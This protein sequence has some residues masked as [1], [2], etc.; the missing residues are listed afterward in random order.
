M[1]RKKSLK[2]VTAGGDLLE[3][4]KTLALSLAEELDGENRGNAN[5]ARQYRETMKD[6]AELEGGADDGG[7][8]GEI[9]KRREND[10]QSNTVRKN[11]ADRD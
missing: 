1:A 7:E 4:L 8:I 9:I 11:R 5:L 6:I 10:G 2:A 3:A